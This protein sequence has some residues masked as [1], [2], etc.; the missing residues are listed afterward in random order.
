MTDP[1]STVIVNPAANKGG[2][3]RRWPA[4]C[5]RL[6]ARLGDFEPCFTT[7]PGHATDLARQAL[8]SGSRRFVAV[9]GDGTVNEVLN[10]LLDRSGRLIE[11]DAVICPIPAGTANELNRALG[12][13]PDADRAYDA[14]AGTGSKA[15][16][17]LRIRCS[18]LDGRPIERFGYL[19]VS[20]GAA[21]AISHRTSQSRW[22][23]KL[24]PA[25]Y[26]LMTPVVTL[27]YRNH[28]VLVAIDGVPQG[29]RRLFTAIVANTENGGGGMKLM[30]G[31][32][33]DDG[34]LDLVEMGDISRAGMLTAIMPKLHR[35]THIHH[36]KVRVTR[37]RSFRFEADV[38]ILVDVD[39]ETVG[40][41]PLEVTVLPLAF[42]VGAAT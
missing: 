39:G 8:L 12:H 5:A 2:A 11:P 24:G 22:I 10:G 33:F 4:I 23:K 42:S 3:G 26:L 40:R 38:D 41:L 1:R 19:M 6:A 36:S 13:L 29:P 17:L 35:G 28:S 34:V 14:A 20:L 21:A 25:A 27:G 18:G 31:A 30:P 9:G 7:A 37:G 15:I 32:L 16:D